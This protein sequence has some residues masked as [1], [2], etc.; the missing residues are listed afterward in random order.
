MF[1]QAGT[2]EK[3]GQYRRLIA[4][5]CGGGLAIGDVDNVMSQL[6][7]VSQSAVLFYQTRVDAKQDF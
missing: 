5:G 3:I 2:G 6:L 4:A 1:R 7:D